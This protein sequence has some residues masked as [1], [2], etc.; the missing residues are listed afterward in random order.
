MVL[1]GFIVFAGAGVAIVKPVKS[2]LDRME[3]GF[4]EMV[5]FNADILEVISPFIVVFI[6]L[7]AE[8]LEYDAA[9][10]D[11]LPIGWAVDIVDI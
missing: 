2:E 7:F 9:V 5:I 8:N 11:F 10:M 4:V 3:L 1:A 6:A